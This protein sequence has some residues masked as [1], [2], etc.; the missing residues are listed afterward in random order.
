MPTTAILPPSVISTLPSAHAGAKLGPAPDA[1]V[2]TGQESSFSQFFA[3]HALPQKKEQ[4]DEGNST[5]GKQQGELASAQ[6]SAPS[7]PELNKPAPT[8][9]EV[10]PVLVLKSSR[11]TGS[12]NSRETETALL[13][14]E[15][16]Q[17]AAKGEAREDLSGP[18]SMSAQKSEK[19]HSIHSSRITNSSDGSLPRDASIAPQKNE[20]SGEDMTGAPVQSQTAMTV[21]ASS[22]KEA[23]QSALDMSNISVSEPALPVQSSINA[24]KLLQSPRAVQDFVP[25]QSASSQAGM[26]SD[27]SMTAAAAGKQSALDGSA[28]HQSSMLEGAPVAQPV[29]G[30]QETS[31]SGSSVP[32]SEFSKALKDDTGNTRLE[33]T[34]S[35]V[36]LSGQALVP[37]PTAAALLHGNQDGERPVAI[38]NIPDGSQITEGNHVGRDG[39]GV[40]GKDMN[41]YQQLDRVSEPVV[42]RADSSRVTVGVHDTSLGW[43]EIKAQGSVGQV[44]ASLMA[45]SSQTHTSLT[46]QLPALT[47][48]LSERHV[49][50]DHIGVEQHLQGGREQGGRQEFGGQASQESSKGTEHAEQE[51]P[52]DVASLPTSLLERVAPGET[53]FSDGSPLSYISVRA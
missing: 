29:Q 3:E 9:G 49:R 30:V 53:A 20:K 47:Q 40:A 6:S 42:L 33:D 16:L 15:N 51:K 13:Q 32:V 22:S 2:K 37:V 1:H 11:V 19:K 12:Q 5:E 14:T 17:Q 38:S 24:E 45:A 50:I 48:F 43:V 31:R 8:H 44:S 25:A 46:N 36:H 18:S 4:I 39:G 27:H 35:S 23:A 41:P 7:L 34:K 21:Q 26:M 28:S 10:S 52:S